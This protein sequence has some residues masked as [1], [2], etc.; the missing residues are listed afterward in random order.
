MTTNKNLSKLFIIALLFFLSNPGLLLCQQFKNGNN[1]VNLDYE[2]FRDKP[3]N[4]LLPPLQKSTF[5]VYNLLSSTIY[6]LS[7]EIDQLSVDTSFVIDTIYFHGDRNFKDYRRSF[8]YDSLYKIKTIIAEAYKD[9]IWLT[10]QITHVIYNS[11]GNVVQINYIGYQ[12]VLNDSIIISIEYDSNGL[13]T[14]EVGEFLDTTSSLFKTAWI[15]NYYYDDRKLVEFK[16]E[17]TKY[18]NLTQPNFIKFKYNI[19]SLLIERVDYLL[20][21]KNFVDSIKYFWQ[22]DEENNLIKYYI[23]YFENSDTSSMYVNNYYYNS[24]GKLQEEIKLTAYKGDQF[25]R[26]DEKIYYYNSTGFPD[27]IRYMNKIVK[28]E[29]D[30]L[31]GSGIETYEYHPNG[32]LTGCSD[33]YKWKKSIWGGK[34]IIKRDLFENIIS[35]QK[36]IWDN[37]NCLLNKITR[38]VYKRKEYR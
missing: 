11:S 25:T 31:D 19:N 8:T 35:V 13:I 24:Y 15:K 14:R 18:P 4:N 9:S 22:F 16:I 26:K 17:N 28:G 21:E 1:I 27:S 5:D 29:V 32:Y 33:F 38:I 37:D 10:H 6:L 2:I 20:P 3:E 30:S 36:E 23:Y 7:S 34:V 12:S